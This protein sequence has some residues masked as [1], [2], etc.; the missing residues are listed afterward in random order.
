MSFDLILRKIY[1]LVKTCRSQTKDYL[2]YKHFLESSQYQYKKSFFNLTI[3]FELAWSRARRGDGVMT[4]EESLERSRLAREML[5]VLLELCEKYKIPVTFATVA[6]VALYNCSEHDKPPKFR[7]FWVKDDWYN[8]DPHSDLESNKDYYGADLIKNVLQS[9]ISHE[10]ASHSF[11]HVDLADS[12]TTKIVAEFEIR[13]SIEIL[14]KI[15]PQISTFVFPNNEVAYKNILKDTGFTNYRVKSNK[16]IEKDEIGLNQFPLG[17]WISP[18]A[19]SSQDLVN[20]I[21]IAVSKK[22]LVNFWCHLYEFGSKGEF[23]SFFGPIFAY[24]EI[25]VEKGI[26]EALNIKDI[27]NKVNE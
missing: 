11:S 2:S 17:L 3:D 16:K 19:F 18:K 1:R 8:I 22:Q 15:N 12:E 4:K 9:N 25:L 21:N 27:I 10:I 24:L 23:K 6:H 20:L 7:P 26:I 5:P 13:Q 14:K